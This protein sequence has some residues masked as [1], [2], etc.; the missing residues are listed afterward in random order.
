MNSLKKEDE[1]LEKRI[2]MQALYY[3]TRK[4][5]AVSKNPVNGKP[6]RRHSKLNEKIVKAIRKSKLTMKELAKKYKVHFYTIKDILNKRTWI[7]V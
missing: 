1:E 6:Y 3:R 5:M 4:E 2:W 7:D